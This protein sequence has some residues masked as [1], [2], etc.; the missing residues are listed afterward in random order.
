[1][2]LSTY[3]TYIY[4]YIYF[5]S[6]EPSRSPRCFSR[7][8]RFVPLPLPFRIIATTTTRRFASSCFSSSS[9]SSSSTANRL[10]LLRRSARS[11]PRAY[12]GSKQR[13]RQQHPSKR[14]DFDPRFVLLAFRRNF[15]DFVFRLR[16]AHEEAGGREKE[17]D[18]VDKPRAGP[19]PRVLLSSSSSSP[20][21]V[22]VVVVVFVPFL[23]LVVFFRGSRAKNR[24][25]TNSRIFPSIS[26][27]P[28]STLRSRP[29]LKSFVGRDPI[30]RHRANLLSSYQSWQFAPLPLPISKH[31]SPFRRANFFEWF[32]AW[33]Q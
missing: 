23:V 17:G 3:N 20:F 5:I 15:T 7:S 13:Q 21:V 16:D 12:G 27:D 24:P 9:S 8:T 2:R 14:K 4:I 33:R 32:L 11:V 10:F 25:V 30:A 29:A 28:R 26:G 19:A 18:K 1:M 22:V 31:L 6:L